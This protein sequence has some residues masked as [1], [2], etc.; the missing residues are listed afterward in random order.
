MRIA[1]STQSGN[2]AGDRW[3]HGFSLVELMVAITLGLLL[4][5]GM[6]QLFSSSKITFQT[7][8]G[9]ARVQENGRFAL[10]LLKR[11]LRTAGTHG[12]C[13]GRIEITNHLNPGCGG[14]AVDFFDPNRAITGWEYASTGSGD[15]FC[16]TG[17][18]PAPTCLSCAPSACSRTSPPRALHRKMPRRST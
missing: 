2:K 17:S 10:E 8:D 18:H 15:D 5:A 6:V 3:S 7:N 9:L 12:F 14:G 11:E 13:A 16:R 4:T 1:H